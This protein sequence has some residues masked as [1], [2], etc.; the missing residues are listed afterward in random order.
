MVRLS[1]LATV[2]MKKVHDDTAQES[3]VQELN[4]ASAVLYL[5]MD[6]S[7]MVVNIA[8]CSLIKQDAAGW[9]RMQQD[10]V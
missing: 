9:A 6:F 4:N 1:S 7:M 2:N 3:A 10:S 5:I 8:R